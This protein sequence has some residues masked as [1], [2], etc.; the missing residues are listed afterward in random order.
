MTTTTYVG[1]TGDTALYSGQYVFQ[2]YT[3]GTKTP[4]PTA[5]ERVIPL[6]RGETFPPVKSNKKAAFWRYIGA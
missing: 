6:Q 4:A 5:E 3:D 1:K 2:S